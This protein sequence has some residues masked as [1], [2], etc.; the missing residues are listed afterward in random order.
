MK[1]NAPSGSPVTTLSEEKSTT[2]QKSVKVWYALW[3]LV[4]ITD[5][6]SQKIIA[7]NNIK[8][9]RVQT[10]VQFVDVLIGIFTGLVS[11]VP[12]TMTVEGNK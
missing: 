7:E 12:A 1:Y 5:N 10:Q 9:A 4:P 8:E 3:G 11:I 6:S 2:V